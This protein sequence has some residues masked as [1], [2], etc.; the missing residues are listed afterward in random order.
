[1]TTTTL[2]A[3]GL[4]LPG[5]TV[6]AYIDAFAAP[7]AT[8]PRAPQAASSVRARVIHDNEANFGQWISEEVFMVA[9][10]L[11]DRGSHVIIDPVKR[12]LNVDKG[13]HSRV[14]R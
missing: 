5:S 4:V 13:W 14:S 3:C 1:M 2:L 11:V 6:C 12:H 8:E 10:S 9:T 7:G